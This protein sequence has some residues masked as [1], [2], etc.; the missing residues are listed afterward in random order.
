MI[1]IIKKNWF[2][3]G[4]VLSILLAR[5]YP[6][7]GTKGGFLKPEW[8]VKYL[9]VCI[10]FFNSGLSLKTQDLKKAFFQYRIHI[11][12]QVFTLVLVPVFMYILVSLLENSPI[13]DLLLKG[14]QVVSCMPPPVSSAVILTKAIGGNEAAAIF[15][16]ALG[17]FL[18]ILVTPMLLYF[19]LGSETSVGFTS[20][21]IQLSLTVLIPILV[22]QF[23]R[24]HVR[25]WLERNRIPFGEISSAMLLLIIYTTF[26]DTFS[27]KNNLHHVEIDELSLLIVAFLVVIIQV[28]LLLFTFWL[29]SQPLLRFQPADTVAILFCSTHKSLTLVRFYSEDFSFRSLEVG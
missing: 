2:L 16:S 9:A 7:F 13:E 22:G 27:M 19:V 5:L 23:F 14:L 29:S 4:I 20:V 10:I 6:P 17:S 25:L 26:C 1:H 15:N 11:F 8:T 12:I 28:V 3:I 21:F 18:G 24:K